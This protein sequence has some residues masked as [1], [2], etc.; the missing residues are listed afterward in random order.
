VD[1]PST[2]GRGASGLDRPFGA[3]VLAAGQSLRL[4]RPKQLVEFR[5]EPLVRR[6][7]RAA[8]EAM[9]EPVVVVIAPAAEAVRAAVAGLPV[10]VVENPLWASGMAS[11][12]RAGVARVRALAPA[13]AGVTL[14][15]CDQPLVDAAHL[16]Q[17]LAE[18]RRTGRPVVASEYAG[19]RGVPVLMGAE[20]LDEVG[21]LEGDTGARD[22]VRRDPARVAAV[23]FPGGELDVDTAA[24]LARAELGRA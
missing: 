12:L 5:G 16:Q 1:D 2:R 4:G 21:A 13:A 11:S 14:I 6:A 23:P 8:V 20:I 22:I 24:D 17:L 10:E 18:R 9:L 7:T 3:V 19:V 15:A